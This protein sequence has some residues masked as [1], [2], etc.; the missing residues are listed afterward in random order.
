MHGELLDRT[1]DPEP[2]CVDRADDVWVHVADEDVVPV[3]DQSGRYRAADRAA[4]EDQISHGVNV[5]TQ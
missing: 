5:T 3:P 4:A 1:L 2:G